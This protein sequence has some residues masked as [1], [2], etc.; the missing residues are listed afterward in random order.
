MDFTS[1]EF[2]SVLLRRWKHLGKEIWKL[3]LERENLSNKTGK[4]LKPF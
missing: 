3:V 2:T 1:D 4:I